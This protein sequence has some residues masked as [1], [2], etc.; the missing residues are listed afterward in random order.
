[1]KTNRARAFTLVELLV[2][3]GIIALLVGILLPA[4]NKARRSAAT[5]KC[6][7]NMRQIG[8]AVLQ[9]T[10]A[11]KGVLMPA[12]IVPLG[13]RTIW[14]EGFSFP[15]ALVRGKYINA[16]NAYNGDGKTFQFPSDSIFRC[17]EGID[18]DSSV[19]INTTTGASSVEPNWPTNT[20]N[21]A[22]S[23]MKTTDSPPFTVA[24]WYQLNSR[25][26]SSSQNDPTISGKQKVSPFMDFISNTPDATI[27]D[28]RFQ[29]KI[30][31]VKKSSVVV[32]IAE[33]AD[34]NWVDQNPPGPAPNGK[35]LYI[36]RIGARHGKKTADG[37]NAFTNVCYFDAHVELKATEPIS[38]I[39]PDDEATL[40][41]PSGFI[42][43]LNRQ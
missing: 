15:N 13:S 14:P 18:P 23:L 40:H 10:T 24:T 20:P 8:Q 37:L 26:N 7:S 36:R 6:A 43:Y 22:C 4:L 16:P 27:T 5:I 11:H 35:M 42:I 31:M 39:D 3:I 41:E 34:P 21:N 25:T 12:W 28:R 33:A 19:L 1:M 38:T 30:S 32:M 29:R 17:P 2:V 9:Y